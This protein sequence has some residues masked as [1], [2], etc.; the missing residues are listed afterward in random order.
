MLQERFTWLKLGFCSVRKSINDPTFF[1]RCS[2]HS[3]IGPHRDITNL[4]SLLS[5]Q[6]IGGIQGRIRDV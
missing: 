5:R 6:R 1:E 3:R 4:L 2:Q